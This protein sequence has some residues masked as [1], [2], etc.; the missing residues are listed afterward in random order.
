[1]IIT[2]SALFIEPGSHQAVLERLKTF[3]EVTFHVASDSRTEL[4]ITIEAQDQL[5]LERVCRELHE[6]IPEIVE[7]AHLYI[8]FEEEIE[9][10]QSGD[11]DRATLYDPSCGE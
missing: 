8:N 3:P 2:G 11:V 9:K 7:V 5:D 10:I 4:V 6:H 1:M